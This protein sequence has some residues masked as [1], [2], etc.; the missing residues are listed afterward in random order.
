MMMSGYKIAYKETL[1]AWQMDLT[2]KAQ[3]IQSL[4]RAYTHLTRQH[5]QI[6]DRVQ[7]A[8]QFITAM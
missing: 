6:Q 5:I 4:A 3:V 1:G 8:M 2:I 7:I